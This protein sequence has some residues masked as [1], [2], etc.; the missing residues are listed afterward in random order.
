LNSSS[1]KNLSIFPPFSLSLHAK[2]I[3]QEKKK[4]LNLNEKWRYKEEELLLESIISVWCV[5]VCLDKVNRSLSH[6]IITGRTPKAINSK[7]LLYNNTQEGKK[8]R[9]KKR[10]IYTHLK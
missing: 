2:L 8:K 4:H 9:K 3:R 6:Q 7:N 1:I 5:V 10:G